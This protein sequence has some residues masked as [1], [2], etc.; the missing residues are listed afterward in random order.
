MATYKEV[1]VYKKAFLLA[2]DIQTITKGFPKGEQYALTDPIRRS[3]R[4]VCVNMAEGFRKTRYKAHFI[5]KITDAG[6]ENS[7]TQIWLDFSVA[8][9]S[10]KKRT[11]KTYYLNRKKSVAC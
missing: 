11:I 1:I 6:M 4:S 5:A 3:S 10:L 9:S 2:M 8:F 7:E